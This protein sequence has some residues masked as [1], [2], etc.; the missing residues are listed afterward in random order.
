MKRVATTSILAVSLLV[1]GCDQA[2]MDVEISET[3][4]LTTEDEASP[5]LDAS[6]SERFEGG[7]PLVPTPAVEPS[8]ENQDLAEVSAPEGWVPAAASSMRLMNFTFG[9]ESEG[10]VYLSRSMGGIPANVLR[11]A[12][13][14]GHEAGPE[15]VEGLPKATLG[16][17]EGVLVELT[18]TYSPG[19]GRPA[20]EGQGLMGIVAARGQE[21][22]TLKM[23]GPAELVAGEKARMQEFARTVELPE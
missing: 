15:F 2:S 9:P 3:R 14:V 18:G 21:I 12:R 11:W 16:G 6:S 19:F 8:A 4:E 10:E 13:Q 7:R 17:A 20:K 1:L 22:W 23:T 5:R